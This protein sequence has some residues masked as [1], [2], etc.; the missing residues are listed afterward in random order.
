M[1]ERLVVQQ[2]PLIESYQDMA[3]RP[4][5]HEN[6]DPTGVDPDQVIIIGQYGPWKDEIQCGLSDCHSWHGKGFFALF[7]DQR[8]TNIGKDCGSEKFGQVWKERANAFERSVK[9]AEDRHIINA[10]LDRRDD[11]RRHVQELIDQ[12]QGA[13]WLAETK[14][15]F[16]DVY[17]KNLVLTLRDRCRKRDPR[18]TRHVRLDKRE[19]EIAKLSKQSEYREELVGTIRG[20]A[21]WGGDPKRMLAN[22]VI[23]VVDDIYQTDMHGL[24]AKEERTLIELWV[25]QCKVLDERIEHANLLV[26]EGRK[27]FTP[28]NMSQLYML[29]DGGDA[30]ATKYVLWDFERGTGEALTQGQYKRQLRK[31]AS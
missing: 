23:R 29:V 15:N 4:D 6:I 8:A 20:L 12:P 21:I 14:R 2:I 27:F 17:P 24:S 3:D 31:F 13:A 1:P 10:V 7:P 19:R 22:Q 18:I 25:S 16:R 30:R 28:D 11:L 26:E 9:N 5:F